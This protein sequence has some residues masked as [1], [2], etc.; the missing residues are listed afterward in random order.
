MGLFTERDEYDDFKV[1]PKKMNPYHITLKQAAEA[2]KWLIFLTLAGFIFYLLATLPQEHHN[3]EVRAADGTIYH[4][5]RIKYGYNNDRIWFR[6]E[7]GNR[8]EL[9]GSY[10]IIDK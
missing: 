5:T 3:Y 2:S 10:T 9:G 1:K 4:T 8:I 6:D 7:N